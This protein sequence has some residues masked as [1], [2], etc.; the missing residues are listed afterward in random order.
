MTWRDGTGATRRAT[1][2]AILGT[3][4]IQQIHTNKAI[5]KAVEVRCAKVEIIKPSVKKA[6]M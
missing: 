1:T 2:G 6:E 3:T 4:R 5:S